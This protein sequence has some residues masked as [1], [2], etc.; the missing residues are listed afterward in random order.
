MKTDCFD[1]FFLY[2]KFNFHQSAGQLK[3]SQLT[4]YDF[5]PVMFV[6]NHCLHSFLI[7]SSAFYFKAI[8]KE[9]NVE[10]AMST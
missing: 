3:V 4:Q 9:K 2:F 6:V 7:T 1:F 5:F 10:L 8:F